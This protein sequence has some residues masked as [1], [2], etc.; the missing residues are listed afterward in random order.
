[1]EAWNQR[2]FLLIFLVLC[3]AHVLA[4]QPKTEV[5]AP[6]QSDQFQTGIIANAGELSGV[7]AA[8]ARV[9]PI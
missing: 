7:A 6:Q 9:E 2:L 4:D 1:M 3:V 5:D 8:A